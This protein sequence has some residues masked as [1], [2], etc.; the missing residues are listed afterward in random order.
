VTRFL[1]PLAIAL[2]LLAPAP[3]ALAEATGESCALIEAEVKRLLCYDL[4]FRASPRKPVPAPEDFEIDPEV[5]AAWP[6]TSMP[7]P[8][9]K[10]QMIT[11]KTISPEPMTESDQFASLSVTCDA[12]RTSLTFWFPGYFMTQDDNGRLL[13]ARI[14]GGKVQEFQTSG[15]DS[16]MSISGGTAA[17]PVIEQLLEAKTVAVT[18][19][20]SSGPPV[21]AEFVL[22]GMSQAIQPVRAACGW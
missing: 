15:A 8:R 19:S 13:K 6:M 9:G 17:I 1:P 12:D 18:V 20:P 10:G 11:I 14:D 22:D 2:A 16:M 7:S 4:V 5:A 3:P 21:E